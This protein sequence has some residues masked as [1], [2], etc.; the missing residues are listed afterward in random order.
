MARARL[1]PWRRD[2]EVGAVGRAHPFFAFW[3]DMDRLFEELWQGLEFV[4]ALGGAAE[5]VGPWTPRIT[6]SE[7]DS[8]I[9]VDVELPGLTEKDFEVALE[10][11]LLTLKGEKRSEHEAKGGELRHVE[12]TYGRF[13][14]TIKLP[15]EVEADKVSAS[16]KHGLLS[17]TLPKVDAA[18]RG[19][20]Q[21]EVRS[22]SSS[23]DL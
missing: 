5:S 8:Q 18:K 1:I 20:R 22:S 7:T 15:C 3:E 10:G 11:A 2:R 16:Y 13:E 4:P 14:R 12:R 21:I 9:R 19:A 17:V 6:L 23:A